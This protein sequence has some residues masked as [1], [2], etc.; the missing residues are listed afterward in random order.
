MPAIHFWGDVPE[1]QQ[2]AVR[3]RTASIVEFFEARY[4]VRVPDLEVH[5]GA[6][7]AA[8]DEATRSAAGASISLYQ[9]RYVDGLLFVRMDAPEYIEH[10]YF[11]AIQHHLSQGE[12]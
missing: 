10:L 8:M 11:Q 5:V 1:S 9:A 4:G 3:A 6:D 7:D 12:S 2:V